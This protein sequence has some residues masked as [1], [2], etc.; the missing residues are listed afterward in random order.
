MS[1][2]IKK[3][4]LM[5]LLVYLLLGVAFCSACGYNP[6]GDYA[7]ANYMIIYWIISIL[8]III[9]EI[10][11]KIG[12]SAFEII[13]VTLMMIF[14]W[15]GQRFFEGSFLLI[16]FYIL[17]WLVSI[18]FLNKLF[19]WILFF[20]QA[21]GLF[22]FTFLPESIVNRQV[23]T[24]RSFVFAVVV[25]FVANW[26]C[27]N[28]ITML[29]SAY[30]ENIEKEKSLDDMIDIIGIKH[31]DAK[32]ATE[33]KSMFL[34]NMSHEI[35]TPI[36]TI[37]GMNEMISRESKDSSI[38]RYSANIKSAG[39]LLLALINDILDTAKI[40]SGKMNLL[41][42]KFEITDV[43]SDVYNMVKPK[44]IEKNLEF[45][46]NI[47]DNIPCEYIG[48]DVKLRQILI[49]LLNNAVKYTIAGW[50][51]LKITGDKKGENEVL[52]ISVEDTG[53]GIKEED[54][55]KLAKKF[56]RIDQAR[57]R[58]V[59]GTGL[60]MSI[61]VNYLDMMG[62]Q[63]QVESEYGQGSNF[64]FDLTLPISDFVPV[65]K[66]KDNE[67]LP[68]EELEEVTG[69]AAP[70]AHI[71]VVDDNSMNLV[72]IKELLKDTEID[73]D[74]AISGKLAV[75]KT[76]NKQYDIIFMDH[77]MPG[78]D[79]IEA[80][81][82]IKSNRMNPNIKSPVIALT[83]NALTGAKETYIDEGF[84]DFLSKP[85]IPSK[86]EAVVKKFLNK[87]LIIEKRDSTSKPKDDV[88]DFANLPKIEGLDY[89]YGYMHLKDIDLFVKTIEDMTKMMKAD[90]EYLSE[91]FEE[92]KAGSDN[93]LD[94][95]RIKVH[96]MKSSAIL[97]GLVPLAG[98]AA[99]LEYASRDGDIDMVL[100]TSPFFLTEWNHYRDMMQKEFGTDEKEGKEV[101]DK[102]E[103]TDYLQLLVDT[104]ENCDIHG[105][106][107][108]LAHLKEF[109]YEEEVAAMFDDM[110]AAVLDFDSNKVKELADK[111]KASL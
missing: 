81:H 8:I 87:D 78:M 7:L 23:F 76:E 44:M 6:T 88:V 19:C 95:F 34:S 32:E 67:E 111:I 15:G 50:V 11:A 61:V 77:M 47:D 17:L 109:S 51:T 28:V 52:H 39:T 71:L 92:V 82:A 98:M 35:R 83:A 13:S 79:G 27:Q 63:L 38:S 14:G 4:H 96:S 46:V 9:M 58:K 59:E 62:T 18:A 54:L 41:S 36:N 97:I 106:D 49:N 31:R 93:G 2:I 37:L 101:S 107:D 108:A 85:V 42:V 68:T 12:D 16:Y 57:N 5:L 89:N 91:C 73:I 25:L 90:A 105:S 45:I 56:V 70:D 74:T 22:V 24:A 86:L 64:F 72:V 80:F 69:F 65:G 103:I 66:M 1:D 84:D 102:T 100:A 20:L 48:D 21:L 75:E 104:V 43:I 3:G 60:G 94:K 55:G 30:E 29:K 10:R 110:E 99:S 53:M 33:A 40:E 26:I